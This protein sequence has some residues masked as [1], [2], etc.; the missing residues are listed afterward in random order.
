MV[1]DFTFQAFVLQCK[2]ELDPTVVLVCHE[3]RLC[4]ALDAGGGELEIG[5]QLES[6]VTLFGKMLGL[7]FKKT[8][9]YCLFH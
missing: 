9:F 6:K 3:G 8:M 1:D 5:T 2:S 4:G 7:F